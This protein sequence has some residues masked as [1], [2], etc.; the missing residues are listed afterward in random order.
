MN[1]SAFSQ[2]VKRI[3]CYTIDLVRICQEACVCLVLF[4]ASLVSDVS[5]NGDGEDLLLRQNRERE[6]KRNETQRQRITAKA[7]TTMP[8]DSVMLVRASFASAIHFHWIYKSG[9]F[10]HR[11][12]LMAKEQQR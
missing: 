7:K 1:N 3:Y 9:K 12:G 5:W 4:F 10:A 6:K 2:R 11:N 8:L